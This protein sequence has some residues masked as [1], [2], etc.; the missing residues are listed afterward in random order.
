MSQEA[1]C[2][3]GAARGIMIDGRKLAAPAV[4]SVIGQMKRWVS[5]QAQTALWQKSFYEH[6]IHGEEDDRQIREYTANNP[7]RWV[8]DR[9]YI[10]DEYSAEEKSIN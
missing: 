1:G 4:S 7:A 9:Y 3:F 2:S 5:I 8:E 6:V 10:E